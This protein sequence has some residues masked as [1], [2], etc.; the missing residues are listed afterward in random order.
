[1]SAGTINPLLGS[2]YGMCTTLCRVHAGSGGQLQPDN[3][4]TYWSENWLAKP[5]SFSEQPA[6]QQQQQ[7]NNIESKSYQVACNFSFPSRIIAIYN[8]DLWD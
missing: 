1:M 7:N 3:E 5:A 2:E 6:A 4:I 8:I